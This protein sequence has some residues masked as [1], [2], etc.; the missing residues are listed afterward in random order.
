MSYGCFFIKLDLP[1]SLLEISQK[2]GEDKTLIQ[3]PGGN[4]SFK[5]DKFLY[6]KGSGQKLE[7]ATK[8]NIFVKTNLDKILKSIS[9]NEE[10]PL[11]D[12]W[13]TKDS[14]KPSIETTLHALMPQKCVLHVHCVNTISWLVREDFYNEIAEL[15]KGISWRFV[16]YKKPGIDLTRAVKKEIKKTFPEV[17]LLCNHGFIAGANTPEEVYELVKKSFKKIR[18]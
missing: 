5:K 12:S 13:N 1:Q 17:I 8:K 9:N 14:I 6:I 16:E 4:I 2:V 10:D 18:G 15:L 3:G 11:A 7:N